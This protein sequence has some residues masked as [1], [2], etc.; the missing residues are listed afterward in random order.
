MKTTPEEPHSAFPW[1][2]LMKEQ[3]WAALGTLNEDGS[4]YVSSAAFALTPS[5]L[6]LHLSQLAAHTRNLMKDPRAS[7]LISRPDDGGADPQV[8][9]RFTLMGQA[10]EV[11]RDS[12]A[13]AP[14]A[15]SYV[16]RFPE[17]S[18]RFGFGD[19]H[20]FLFVPAKGNYV[21]GFG[22]AGRIAGETIREALASL[23]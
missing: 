9:P 11:T 2:E 3:R 16:E 12:A 7:L 10:G 14:A 8:L 17:S 20:L 15:R 6:L 23:S 18:M 19:F 13:F 1:L 4:P 22:N 5:G 21:G